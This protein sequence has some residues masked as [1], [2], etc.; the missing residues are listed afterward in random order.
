VRV[1]IVDDDYADIGTGEVGEILV[2]Q[3]GMFRGYL[4]MPTATAEL[5]RDGWI[6]TGDLGRLDDRGYVSIVGRKKDVVRRSGE[7]ISAAEV[8]MT[9]R[10][11]EGILDAAVLAVPDADRGE[12]VKAYVQ[13]VQGPRP[14]QL[15]AAEIAEYCASRLAPHK[16]PRYIE[17]VTEFPRTPSM[18]IRKDALRA[19]PTAGTQVWDRLKGT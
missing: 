5:V 9:L 18:R 4:N 12:E 8:E 11:H 16:V 15:S 14:T 2:H 3:P 13:L 17:F 19:E 7:N 10:A 1:R 6:C